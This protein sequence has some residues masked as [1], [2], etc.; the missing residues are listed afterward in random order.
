MTKYT[1]IRETLDRDQEE[2]EEEMTNYDYN[3]LT[4]YY[5][6]RRKLKC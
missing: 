1:A 4:Y 3:L 6:M 2:L 5:T